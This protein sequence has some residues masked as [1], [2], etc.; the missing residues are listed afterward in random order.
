M[1]C[2]RGIFRFANLRRPRD[3]PLMNVYFSHPS[4]A[5]LLRSDEIG[6]VQCGMAVDINVCFLKC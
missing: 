5:W 1:M 6:C 2:N 4:T 3:I